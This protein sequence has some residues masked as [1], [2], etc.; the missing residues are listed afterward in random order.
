M[1]KTTIRSSIW[2]I[3]LLFA[4][5]NAIA[6][7][8][9]V[10][11]LKSIPPYY[12]TTPLAINASGE[13]AGAS[14]KVAF[15]GEYLAGL[16]FRWTKATGIQSLG[17]GFASSINGA[18]DVAGYATPQNHAFL[19][20]H[21]A[22]T[23]DLGTL[24]GCC[25]EAWAI[26][27]TDSIVGDSV[28]PPPDNSG[29]HPFLWT[30]TGGM[31]DLETLGGG[32]YSASAS[33]ISDS[34]QVIGYSEV[35]PPDNSDAFSWTQGGGMQDIGQGLAYA[36]NRSGLIVGTQ[37]CS[38]VFHALLWKGGTI[39]DLGTLGGPTSIA[40]AINGPG[41]VVGTST[42][43]TANPP[44]H[45]FIWTQAAG[46]QDLNPLVPASIQQRWVL[47]SGAA[48]N[49]AG[50][51]A[52]QALPITGSQI[53][54]GFILSPQMNVALKSS[55]NPSVVGE[56]VTFTATITSVVGPPPNGEGVTFKSGLTVLGTAKLSKGV[57]VFQT[58]NL[59]QGTH[60]VTAI[61]AGDSNYALA[62]SSIL[63]QVV[64]K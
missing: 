18:G 31:Q 8:Y 19:W 47:V 63:N 25:S 53:T 36:V 11:D 48:I 41:A 40:Y 30:S 6:Q 17:T 50:Q 54:H 15:Q 21:D 34:G 2:F 57:A 46:M 58:S 14:T 4:S 59:A 12:W 5:S 56:T 38:S 61:Y 26:N 29:G 27:A 62:K 37:C 20:K 39:Q 60:P 3:L 35:P 43:T 49:D 23:Q 33:G 52:V 13:V 22:T 7:Q 16:A 10:T 9:T 45:A 51:I 44:S 24:G 64:N 55:P 1:P 28:P 32:S 42:T